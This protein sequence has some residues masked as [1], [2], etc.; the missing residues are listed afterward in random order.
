MEGLL[1]SNATCIVLALAVVVAA[2]IDIHIRSGVTIMN[3]LGLWIAHHVEPAFLSFTVNGS[4]FV[5]WENFI[6]QGSPLNASLQ[7]DDLYRFTFW[8]HLHFLT[9]VIYLLYLVVLQT[10]CLESPE[11]P[12][13]STLV[14]FVLVHTSLFAFAWA[15]HAAPSAFKFKPIPFIDWWSW[16]WTPPLLYLIPTVVL[17]GASLPYLLLRHPLS[18]Q[19]AP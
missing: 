10:I 5:P 7:L 11:R 3:Q 1:H 16:G 4:G 12:G 17:V 19:Q 13:W 8:P 15:A 14:G 9:F 6:R 2:T 18:D